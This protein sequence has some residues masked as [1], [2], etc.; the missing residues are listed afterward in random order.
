MSLNGDEW[1]AISRLLDEALDL[2]EASRLAWV[3]HLGPEYDAVR[4]QLRRMLERP[5][6][7]AS[8]LSLPRFDAGADDEN[9]E[10]DES[11]ESGVPGALVGPYRLIRKLADGGMG[12]V[13]LAERADGLVSRPVALKLPRGTWHGTTLSDRMAR[14]REIL[15]RLEHPHIAR[16]YDTGLTTT[17]QPYLAIEYVTG[18]HIDDYC[19][20]H[21]LDVTSRLQLFLQVLDAVAHAHA[22]LIVHRDLKPSN[23]LVTDDGQVKLLDFG[24]AKLLT[25]GR[26][27][28]TQLTDTGGRP[29]T[30]GYASP[31]QAAGD[32]LTI[33]SDIYSLGVVLHELLTGERPE[34]AEPTIALPSTRAPGPMAPT[35]R[36][37]V[38]TI[39]LKA[40]KFQAAERYATVNAL[41]DDIR[42]HLRGLPILARPDSPWYRFSKFARRHALPLAGACLALV[43]VLAASGV[44]VWQARVAREEQRRAEEVTGFITSIFE[45][46]SPYAA[47]GQPL[48]AVDLLMQARAR[49]DRI[50][51][52][53]P[54]LRTELLTIIGASLTD[55][56][57]MDE[58]EAVLRQAADDAGRTLG[59][60]HAL[61]LRARAALSIAQRFIGDR[62]AAATALDDLLPRLRRQPALADSLV[63]ALESHAS[64]AMFATNWDAAIASS[65]EMIAVA[66]PRFGA[67]HPLTL[68][69]HWSLVQA[70]LLAGRSDEAARE[71]DEV[72]PRTL[73]AY[74][75]DP[76][77]PALIEAR[78]LYGRV[79]T[80][81]GRLGEGTTLISQALDAAA[82]V[83]GPDSM[84][85]GFYSANLAARQ[86]E[87]G[88]LAAALQTADRAIAATA[89]SPGPASGVH[90]FAHHQRAMILLASRDGQ[91]ALDQLDVTISKLETTGE[92]AAR[93]SL[94]E[95]QTGR[96]LA[97]A[98]AGRTTEA[99][100]TLRVLDLSTPRSQ[101]ILGMV[102]RLAGAYPEALETLRTAMASV[103]PGPRTSRA[104]S[105]YL[106]E[107]GLTQLELGEVAAASASLQKAQTLRA[108]FEWHPSPDHADLLAGLG[109]VAQAQGDSDEAARWLDEAAAYWRGFAPASRWAA[110]VER[111]RTTHR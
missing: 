41:A 72:F 64:A 26:A 67:L 4:P 27:A 88:D 34:P 58:A 60:D 75:D 109:R 96:A 53:T 83:F 30:P 93:Q 13:W 29:L 16:L 59:P 28:D 92:A 87:L 48:T 25:Q 103:P 44:A 2:P 39:V 105:M 73:E 102:Q 100:A 11:P 51:D 22:R 33:A 35:L 24:I 78:E 74:S 20:H 77:A 98:Y 91:A 85:V 66:L 47:A 65:Q 107:I 45:G 54:A 6:L 8:R 104:R 10:H 101:R 31:E 38:D 111:W 43:G 3:E 5:P 50:D 18:R 23:I 82:D 106:V 19:A 76:R 95:A 94:P 14:E 17:G 42:R 55:L 71:A 62:D 69:G 57:A 1:T 70:Y 52:A 61:T 9:D 7:P 84:V 99:L 81:V 79:L 108:A 56:Q 90:A 37:D 80:S 21:A 97:L 89:V 49:I 46:A 40:L 32:P 68:A 15:A 12:S 110:D 63:E 36:G 86:L